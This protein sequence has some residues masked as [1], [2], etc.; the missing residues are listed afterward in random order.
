MD[1]VREWKPFF[2]VR[3]YDGLSSHILP[4]KKLRNDKSKVGG[5]KD[6]MKVGYEVYADGP[7]RVLRLSEISERQKV[8]KTFNMCGKMR[9]RIPHLAIHMLEVKVSNSQLNAF[10]FI[11]KIV[12]ISCFVHSHLCIMGTLLMYIYGCFT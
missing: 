4:D 10:C 5:L 12:I 2:K 6:L 3:R 9:L 8:D 1:K 7:I 11:N